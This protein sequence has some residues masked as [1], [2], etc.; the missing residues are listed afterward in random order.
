M[1]TR[2]LSAV[3][4]DHDLLARIVDERQSR[5]TLPLS[6]AAFMK[7]QQARGRTAWGRTHSTNVALM[8]GHV[9]RASATRYEFS[10]MLDGR[11]VRVSGIGDLLPHTAHLDDTRALAEQ[12]LDD[13]A[14]SGAAVV[15][16]FAGEGPSWADPLGFSD[17]T[18]PTVE[19][20]CPPTPRPGAPM[21]S[22]RAG[23]DTDLT[24]IVGM[25]DTVW[26]SARRFHL[27]RDAD[28]IRHG[29]IVDRLLAG[30]SPRGTQRLEFFATEEG[31]NAAAYVVLRV[32]E[33]EWVLQQCGDRDPS[34]AR[35][36]AII[37]ALVARDP[38]AVAPR[39]RAWL[40]P[41][42]VPPQV[43]TTP[44]DA[45][46]GYVFGRVLDSGS[47]PLTAADSLFW[48]SDCF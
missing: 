9:V 44:T 24:H 12:M 1:A 42:V 4:A 47:E 16:L 15:L 32:T 10:A 43:R 45:S 23:E 17:I 8:D 30:L 21:L 31:T 11:S 22:I 38:T 29:I 36:G 13:A 3:P 37:Q 48:R 33:T 39:I 5:A 27:V 7:W 20:T 34:G 46:L 18:P 6:P 14:A 40:P 26:A 28:F 35:V 2:V 25:G 19:L 41:G